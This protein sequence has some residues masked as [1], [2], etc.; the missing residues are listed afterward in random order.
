MSD[1]FK[2]K[3]ALFTNGRIK[4]NRVVENGEVLYVPV[5]LL[6]FPEATFKPEGW[7]SSSSKVKSKVKVLDCEADGFF[8]EEHSSDD[9]ENRRKSFSRAKNKLF[10]LLLNNEQLNLFVTITFDEKQID[11]YSYDEIVRKMNIWLDNRV[12][13]HGLGYILVPEFHKD[14]AVHFHGVMNS[15]GL[16]LVDSGHKLNRKKVYNI[17]DFPYGFTWVQRITDKQGNYQHAREAV[18]KY[19]YKYVTKTK[20][21][22]VVGGYYLH[23]GKLHSPRFE[24]VNVDYFAFDKKYEHSIENAPVTF[25]KVPASEFSGAGF[26]ILRTVKEERK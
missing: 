5:E 10:D 14:K 20:G 12:R 13:R 23:G 1:F 9:D 6:I 8:E 21:E 3:G 26:N 16:E 25:K 4:Y 15:S 7:E 11:R 24:F 17:K 19:I 18:G 22:K 2:E